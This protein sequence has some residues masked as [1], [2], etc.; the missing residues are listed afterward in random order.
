MNT[1]TIKLGDHVKDTITGF[2]GIVVAITEWMN[3]CRR[4]S[5]QP[6]ALSKETGAPIEAQSFDESQLV[7]VKAKS[8]PVP[9]REN[10]G[11]RPEP[12]QFKMRP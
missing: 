6:K 4:I 2:N 3:Q 7:M 10:G 9:R 8:V 5:V 12:V 1:R 11:P